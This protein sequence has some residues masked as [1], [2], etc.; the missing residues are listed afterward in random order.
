M[1]IDDKYI[2][3]HAGVL[4]DTRSR[5]Q[6]IRDALAD[7][8]TAGTAFVIAAGYSY[9]SP[10]GQVLSDL[11][12]IIGTIYFVWL[13]RQ[14]YKPPLK[15]PATSKQKDPGERNKKPSG[16][17]YLGNQKKTGNELWLSGKDIGTHVL[18]LG[19][20]GAGKTEGLISM[21]SNSLTW[22]SGFIYIDGKADNSLWAKLYALARRFGRDDDIFVLNYLTGNSD[23][24]SVSNTINPFTTGSSSYLT[25]L[26]VS[27]MDESKGE[28]AMW[29]GRAVALLGALMPI[30]TYRR[31]T[32]GMPLDVKVILDS[33]TLQSVIRLSRDVT[34]PERIRAALTTTYLDTL[35]G[36]IAAAFADDGSEA[37]PGPNDPPRDM[38]TVSQ[39]HN[40]LSMQFTRALQ[41]LSG[42]YWHIFGNQVADVVMQDVVLNRRI[43]VVLIPSLEKSADEAANLGKIVTAAIKGMM[44]T[45]L[46]SS[47]EG[48]WSGV[49][50][51]KLSNSSSPFMTVFDEVGYYATQGMAVMA[52]QAR[53]LGFSLIFAS[54]DIPSME[55]RVKE[56]ARSITANCNLKIFGKLEESLDTQNFFEKTVGQMMVS[57]SSGMTRVK[58]SSQYADQEGASI[59]S[60]AK[61]GWGDLRDQKEGEIHLT[62]QSKVI[63]GTLYYANPP[64]VYAMRVHKLLG[65]P[66][67][68][69][70]SGTNATVIKGLVKNLRDPAWTAAA[71]M[72]P[73]EES[74][75]LA[76]IA[77]GFKLGLD[78]KKSLRDAAAMAIAALAAAHA[79]EPEPELEIADQEEGAVGDPEIDGLIEFEGGEVTYVDDDADADF[80][81]EKP[82]E[83]EETELLQLPS[84]DHDVDELLEGLVVPRQHRTESEPVAKSVLVPVPSTFH[85]AMPVEVEHIL[86]NAAARMARSIEEG[87]MSQAA[88]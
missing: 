31:D 48:D 8:T 20:T 41:S 6:K 63:A 80:E 4:R 73:L 66:Y 22:G 47:V 70:V 50:D 25:N 12:L 60:R 11:L 62:W 24:G 46:G 35:P 36:Y 13:M 40:F 26:L 23:L 57:E 30:L 44:G 10:G 55:L 53:S 58:G 43:L 64:R 17:I 32:L 76:I 77:Q 34:I 88:Q 28:N 3:A 61:A 5:F 2:K 65:L 78:R 33:I 42:D 19:T 85:P 79:P 37:P 75:D 68:D 59:Q 39:Q 81:D 9:S 29:K 67:P 21:V 84:P 14:S 74:E 52:A 54:Q 87:D 51:N 18:Y 7:P 83:V 49:I 82:L 86:A 72:A 45:T 69:S 27:L 38:S 15:L 71:V 1:V 16:I 56:E